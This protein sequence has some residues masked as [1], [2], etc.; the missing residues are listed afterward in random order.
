MS[1]TYPYAIALFTTVCL[2]G[3]AEPATFTV[4]N[5]NASGGG[6]LA[7]AILDANAN[8]GADDIAFA[9]PGTGPFVIAPSAA[10]PAVDDEVVIDART[11]AGYQ[12]PGPPQIQLDG[13]N[14]PGATGLHLSE[15][16]FSE[17][18][19]LALT[20]WSAGMR[21]DA[22][23][24]IVGECYVGLAP[25]GNA[26]GNGLGIDT[27]GFAPQLGGTGSA[28]A[29]G[30]VISANQTGI[31]FAVPGGCDSAL[32][33]GNFI[34]TDPSG[35]A[36]RPNALGIDLDRCSNSIVGGSDPDE[37]NVISGNSGTG[38]HIEGVEPNEPADANQV[39]GNY[40]GVAADGSTALPNLVGAVLRDATN[41][42]IGD[43]VA[44]NVIAGNT[45][46]G[47]VIEGSDTAG[48]SVRSNA[49]GV[50]AQGALLPNGGDAVRVDGAS[51]NE[52]GSITAPNE[53]AYVDAGV[54]VTAA[55]EVGIFGNA[56]E[57]SG[58]GTPLAIDLGDDGPT[59]NDP[60]D[61]DTGANLL[62][63]TPELLSATLN[64]GP[65]PTLDLSY[66]V[67]SDP[68]AAD[69]P[70]LVDLFVSDASGRQVGDFIACL[71]F[72]SAD[73]A[74]GQAMESVPVPAGVELDEDDWIIATATSFSN[75]TSEF[76]APRALPEPAASLALLAAAAGLTALRR[77]GA[78][79]LP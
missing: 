63:N 57:K 67:D 11:Q 41:T 21:I 68:S 17:V 29:D 62:Q 32:I 33:L 19:G 15:G 14:A 28:E 10:L 34:G 56:F 76:G 50:D 2:A 24:V 43:D 79:Q 58:G 38:L 75:D 59:A 39:V 45:S 65:M 4:T 42:E 66:R 30:N 64:T 16:D 69:Y 18:Y 48:T 5:S 36:A 31:A 13:S 26:A 55:A 25:N 49:I 27:R 9:I 40:I 37:R 20:N 73:F 1:R 22:D 77:P 72:T 47:L 46:H 78:S 23:D 6:S 3:A 71:E 12:S 52:V 51:G 7:Q 35:Q 70:L 54:T 74:A 60:G 53:I 61:F 44:G 8:P